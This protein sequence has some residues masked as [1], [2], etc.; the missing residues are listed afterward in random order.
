MEPRAL[1]VAFTARARAITAVHVL[2]EAFPGVPIFARAL[3]SRHAAEMKAAGADT[4]IIANAE[5][6]SA[7]AGGILA[8][9]G[10]NAGQMAGLNR[11]LRQQMDEQAQNLVSQIGHE[12]SSTSSDDDIFR[13][14]ADSMLQ[15]H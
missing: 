9:M 13:L 12:G 8:S 3:D 14:N 7:L 1:A 11:L 10:V 15:V 2:R 5:A 6:A 4:V